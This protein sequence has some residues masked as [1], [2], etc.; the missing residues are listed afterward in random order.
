MKKLIALAFMI[1]TLWVGAPTPV[2][3][4][5]PNCSPGSTDSRCAL[6][7]NCQNGVCTYTP[8]EPL[9]CPPGSLDCQTGTVNFPG[10][11]N[12]VFKLA[13]TLGGLFAVVMLVV[14]GI[15]YMLSESGGDISK[16]KER[17]KAALWGLL[18]L[19]TSWLILSAVNPKLL[20]FNL[21]SLGTLQQPI[22]PTP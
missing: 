7:P 17:A 8:L 12:L 3:A 19:T 13:I 2:H 14:A 5:V 4:D 10:F 22:P 11:L 21:T 15:G 18:L 6:G 20:E 16:A 1:L 9:P